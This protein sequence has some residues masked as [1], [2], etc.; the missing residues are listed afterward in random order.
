MRNTFVGVT[1]A[2]ALVAGLFAAAHFGSHPAEAPKPQLS[3]AQIAAQ[4]KPDFIG[5]ETIGG[6]R[7]V[8][9]PAKELPRS[10]SNGHSS[11]NS[12]GT[13]PRE[14]PPPPGWKIPRCRA[15]LGLRSARKPEQQVRVTFRE[16]GFR[17][18]LALILRFP[19][20]E[21][22]NGDVVEVHLDRA[23]W[24]IPVRSCAAKF[25]LAIQSIKFADVPV[26]EKSKQLVL[27]FKP[28]SNSKAVVIAVPTSGLAETLKAIRRIDK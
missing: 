22:Q 16:F 28:A 6:W 17:R 25:C 4:I 18:V 15:V 20:S 12:A 3:T 8:C 19:L 24:Q 11:G 14:T 26:L 1:L 5:E 9:G 10:P 2:V 27:S 21:V 23:E 7:L 13:A